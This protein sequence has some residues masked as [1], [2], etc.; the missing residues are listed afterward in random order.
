VRVGISNADHLRV[1]G[2]GELKTSLITVVMAGTGEKHTRPSGSGMQVTGVG[3]P[4]FTSG[5]PEMKLE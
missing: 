1:G 4:N 5:L 2:S 3:N